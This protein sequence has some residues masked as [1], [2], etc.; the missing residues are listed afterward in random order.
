MAKMVEQFQA[1]HIIPKPY[2]LPYGK[3]DP[4]KLQITYQ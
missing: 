4:A 3:A 2:D 1:L